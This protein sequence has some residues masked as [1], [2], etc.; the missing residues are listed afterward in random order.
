MKKFDAQ[1]VATMR[2][3]LQEARDLLVD[4][5]GRAVIEHFGTF[6]AVRSAL[7]GARI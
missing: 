3:A 1:T 6:H 2:T 4:A 7:G 5:G